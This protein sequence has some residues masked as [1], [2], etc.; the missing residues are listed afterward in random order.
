MSACS[1]ASLTALLLL[2]ILAGVAGG[3]Y[4]YQQLPKPLKVQASIEGP[5]LGHYQDDI[6]Q[7]TPVTLRFSYDFSRHNRQ[8]MPAPQLSAARLDLIGEVLTEGVSLEPQVEGKWLWQDENSLVFMPEQAWP[9]GQHYEVTFSKD[10]FARDILLAQQQYQFSSQPLTAEV[11][12]L[13]FYQHPTEQTTRQIV[14]TLNFSH[15][16]DIVF[17]AH[18]HNAAFGRHLC[19]PQ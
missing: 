4:Y 5:E 17:G 16:V 2:L 3:V 9:A 13:R 10:I 15:P 12:R 7:P 19:Y 1:T 18:H 11:N 8:I 6:E 14:A